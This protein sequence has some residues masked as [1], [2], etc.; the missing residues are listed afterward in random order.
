MSG[1]TPADRAH[2]RLDALYGVAPASQTDFRSIARRTKVPVNLLM[3]LDGGAGDLRAV[4]QQAS[5]I[6]EAVSAGKPLEAA[7]AEVAGDEARGMAILETAYDLADRMAPAPEAAPGR[8]NDGRVGLGEGIAGAARSLGGGLV[9]ASGGALD[10]LGVAADEAWRQSFSDD[11]SQAS[12]LRRAGQAAGD[13]ARGA[14]ESIMD[15]AS[16]D[17]K[18]RREGFQ[19]SGNLADPSSWSLGD[20]PSIWGAIGLTAEGLGSM[21][22]VVAAGLLTKNP[23]I[24]GSI[25][26]GLM[27]AGEGVETGRQFVQDAA[28]TLDENGRPVIEGLPEYK[29]LREAGESH[30]RA[31]SE[32]TRRAENDAG[33]RQGMVAGLGGAATN[34]I[35]LSADGWLGRGGRLARAGKKGAASALEE[36]AQ[37]TAEGVAGGSGIEAATG[38]DLDLMD[39]SFGDFVAGAL[40]GG[41]MGAGA[42]ALG[43]SNDEPPASLGAAP[44]PSAPLAL[45][46]PTNGGTIFGRPPSADLNPSMPLGLPAPNNGGAIIP[47]APPPG[48]LGL[49]APEPVTQR[50]NPEIAGAPLGG[51][52]PLAPAGGSSQ[53]Q[54]AAPAPVSSP[55]IGAAVPPLGA[56]P[57]PAPI[58]PPAPPAG[59]VEA[60]AQQIA[61]ATP[62]PQAEPAPRFPD[63]KPGA[64]VTLGN[65]D[66]ANENA[67]FLR[68]TP[69]GALVRIQG[70]EIE[71][72]PEQF[73]QARNQAEVNQN[74]EETSRGELGGISVAASL[75]ARPGPRIAMT[76]EEEFARMTPEEARKR[77]VALEAG[78]R[79]RGWNTRT[80]NLRTILLQRIALG[81][82][83]N[84]ESSVAEDPAS[85]PSSPLGLRDGRNDGSAGTATGGAAVQTGAQDAGS[86]DMRPEPAGTGPAPVSGD[87]GGVDV[88][89]DA[90]KL[91][92]ALNAAR[93]AGLVTHTTKKGKPKVGYVLQGV[94]K[95]EADA[96]DPYSFRKDGGIFVNAARADAFD[97]QQPAQIDTQ[98]GLSGKD[99][100]QPPQGNGTSA[101]PEPLTV[102]TAAAN[103]APAPTDAQK[104]A[105]NYRKGHA[106]WNGLDLSI[107][108]AKGQERSGTDPNGKPWSV[109]MPADYGYFRR[110]E[111]SDGDQVDFYMGPDEGSDFV[112]VVDQKDLA[113]GAFDEHKVILGTNSAAEAMAIYEAG[114][115][116]GRGRER[117]GGIREMHPQSLRAW[118]NNGDLTKPA[119]PSFDG[120]ARPMQ[121]TS[122]QKARDQEAKPASTAPE[123]AAVGVDPRE[124]SEI[125]AEFNDAQGGMVQDGDRIHHLFDAPKKSEIVRL[126]QKAEVRSVTRDG[127][128]VWH[129]DKGWMTPAE[130]RAQIEEWKAHARAQGET[131]ENADKVVLSLFDLTGSWSLPWEEAGYQVFRFDIQADPEMGDVNNFSTDFFGDW[132]GDFDGM[133]IYAILAACPCTDFASSGSRHFAAKDA[134]G[135]TVASV[136]LVHQ[137][138]ATIEHFRPAVWAIEN[139]VGRI[140]KLGGLPPWRLSFEPFHLGDTYTKT[141]LLW[142]RFNG[143]LPV[144][145]VEPV[146]GSKM[147]QKYGGK[148]LATKNARSATPEG[149]AYGFFMANNATDHP[150]MA[151]ANK[152]DRLDR[153]LI[154]QAIEAGVTA[155]AIT[156]AVS[157]FYYMELD[158]A[159]ANQAIRDLMKPSPSPKGQ[160]IEDAEVVSTTPPAR[161]EVERTVPEARDASEFAAAIGATA[162]RPMTGLDSLDFDAFDDKT[163]EDGQNSPAKR[164]GRD[165]TGRWAKAVVKALTTVAG[166][167]PV[168]DKKGKAQKPVSFGYGMASELDETNISLAGKNGVQVFVKMANGWSRGQ[169]QTI[170]FQ[171]TGNPEKPGYS[172]PF[173]GG[174]TFIPETATPAEAAAMIARAV[175]RAEGAAEQKAVKAAADQA[176]SKPA[177]GGASNSGQTP[178]A[179]PAAPEPA[180]DHPIKKHLTGQIEREKVKSRKARAAGDNS[181]AGI[182]DATLRRLRMNMWKAEEAID[183]AIAAKDFAPFAPHQ[184]DFPIA[185]EALRS[186]I[187]RIAPA[188]QPDVTETAPQRGPENVTRPGSGIAAA[189][190]P[191]DQARMAELKK[192]LAARLRTQ[193]SSGLDPEILGMA[194]EL[195]GLY[196]KAGARKFGAMLRDFMADTGLTASESQRYMRAAYGDVRDD[197]DLNGE[198]VSGFD[199]ADQVMA[200]VRAALAEE[201]AAPAP[202]ANSQEAPDRGSIGQNAQKEDQPDDR[203]GSDESDDRAG[204]DR[205]PQDPEAGAERPQG[206]RRGRGDADAGQSRSEPAAGRSGRGRDDA[207]DGD[208]RGDGRTDDARRVEAPQN[209]VIPEGGLELTGGEKTRAR[210]AVKAIEIVRALEREG[211]PATADER[212]ALAKYGGA[213]V[214]APALPNS[215]GRIRMQDIA[216]D[217]DR[218]LTPEERATV[219]KTSQYAFYTAEPVLRNMW[220]LAQRLGFKGGEVFE[221]GMGVG[222]FAGTM[223][224]GVNGRYHGIELD[225]ITAKI[226]AALYPRHH[227]KHGDFIQT[228]MPRDFYDLVIGNPP[229]SQTKITADPAYPQGFMI[230]DYFFA[231]SLDSVRPGGLLMFVTSA[232]TM[233]KRDAKAR[234]YLADRADLVGAVR[235]P[236]TAFAENG[237][238]VTTDIIVLRKRLE[239]EP[240]AN[241]AWRESTPVSV[242]DGKGGTVELNV[243][244]YFQANPEMILGE[245]GAFDTLVGAPRIGVRP[246]EGANLGRDLQTALASFPENV[247]SAADPRQMMDGPRDATSAETKT[248]SYYLKDG[249]LWQF[250]GREGKPVQRKGKSGGGMS[251]ADYDLIS[252]LVPIRNALRAVYAADLAEADATQ[253]RAELNRLY[254]EFVAKNGPINKVEESYRRPSAVELEGM[255]QRAAEDARSA[256]LGFD[257]GSFDAG[258]MIE[259]G[260]SMAAIARARREAAQQPGYR[261]GTFDP[262]AVPDKVL[263]R[264]PN[265]DAFRQDPESFRLRAIEKFDR[266]TGEATKTRVF[267]ENA[268]KKATQPKISSPEDAL[269]YLLA[270]TGRI[271]L[272]RIAEL[273]GSAPATVRAELK[274][275]IFLNPATGEF[276][277]RTRYLSGNVRRKLAEAEA[278]ISRD[279]RFAENAEELRKVIPDPIPRSGIVIPLGAHWFDHGFYAEF[280]KSKGLRLEATFKKALGR[281]N[282]EGDDRSPAAKN[283]WG[284]E[285]VP[286]AD[287]MR[288]AMNNKPMRVTRTVKNED[289]TTTSFVDEEATQAASDKAAE[290]QAAFSEWLWS[291]EARAE[292]LEERYNEVFNAEVA[293]V[294]DGAYLT[295]PGIN[296]GW[297]WRP[298]QTAV[299]ARILQSGSTYMA[300]AVGAG[301]TSAMIGA[302]MEARRLGIAQRPWYSVPNHMLV[303]FATE[304]QEQYPLANILV[305]DETNFQGDRRRQFVADAASGD[306]DAVI[307]THSAFELIPSSPAAKAAVVEEMLSDLRE[308]IEDMGDNPRDRQAGQDQALLGALRSVAGALGIKEEKE[309]GVSTAKKIAQ[310]MEQAEQRLTA[311]TQDTGKDEVFTFDEIGVDM[312][313][314]DEAH[315]FRKLSFATTNGTIKGIDPKGSAMSMDLFI[316]SRSVERRNPGRGLVL[317]SGTPITNT[318]AELYSLQRFMQPQAL[319]DKNISAFDSW[320]ATFGQVTSELEQTPDGGYKE[321]SRFSKF[322]NT[323]ELSLMVRQ[324]MDIVTS[325]DLEKYVTRPKLRG[326]GRNLVVV[327]ATPEQKAYQQD[328]ARRMRA[329]QQRKGPPKPGDDIMLNVVN[330]GRLAAIDMRL[331]DPNSTGE[332]SKLERL[333]QNVYAG[334]KAGANA[335]L[336]GVKPEGG[337]TD[338]P[339]MRGPTTQIVFS[340]LGVSPSKHNPSFSVHRHIKASLIRMGVPESDIIMA[341]DLKSHVAKQRAFND[342][343]DGKRRIL[344][345][346][347]NLF[348]GV[349]AQRRLAQIHNLDP[350]WFPAD[351]E[352]RNGRGIRQG[353][354][355]PEIAINDYSTK[356][357]YD[358]TMWQM[359]ERKAGFISGFYRGDPTMRDMEDLGEESAFA[360]AKAMTTSDPRV[361]QLTEMKTERDKLRRRAGAVD[362]QR[363]RLRAQIRGAMRAAEY[364][365]DEER[366][367]SPVAAMIPDLSG[368][369][370]KMRVGATEFDSRKEAGEAIMARADALVEAGK[371]VDDEVIGNIGGFPVEARY[372]VISQV[373]GLGIRHSPA[374]DLADAEFSDDPVGLI[375]KLEYALKKPERYVEFYQADI[376][377][378]DRA[379]AALRGQLEGVKEFADQGKLD[380]LDAEIAELEAAL[381]ADAAAEA[382][383]AKESRFTDDPELTPA[384]A[385]QINAAARAELEKVGIAGRVRAE[386]GGEGRAA[387]T[388]QRGVIRIL[389]ARSGKWRHT[390]DHEIIH[391]LRDPAIWGGD[392]GIFTRDE[393]RALVRAARADEGIAARVEAA[394]SDLDATGQTEEMVAELYADWAQA[395]REAPAGPVRTAFD[396]IRSFFR[397]VASAL[398]GEGFQDAAR[399][400]ER[401]ANGRIGG[402]GP[403]GP[404]GGVSPA[405]EQRDTTSAAFRRW[406]GDSK[407]VDA[408]GKPR[409][410][411]HATKAGDFEAFDTNISS[412][413]QT[414]GRG[415]YFATRKSDL[416]EHL[417]MGEYDEGARV[418]TANLSIQNPYVWDVSTEAK[419]VKLLADLDAAGIEGK[420]PYPFHEMNGRRD[421]GRFTAWAKS[422]GYD[423]V[424]V[425]SANGRDVTEIVAF[426]PTQIKSVNNRGTFE[427][428]NP[429]IREQRDM[430]AIKD[431][432]RAAS[433]RGKGR[434]ASAARAMFSRD[435]WKKSPEVFSN[436]LTDA[437]GKN[438]R[439][440]VLGAV[441]GHALFAELGKNLS[442]AQ[443]YL[444]N[445]QAMDTERNDWQARAAA[446]VDKWSKAGRQDGEANTRLM[447]L[448]HESTLAGIDPSKPDDWVHPSADSARRID[449]S[450]VA[451]PEQRAFARRV[452]EEIADHKATYSRLK[453]A[454]DALPAEFQTLYSEIRDEYAAMADATDSAVLENVSIANEVAVKRARRQHAKEMQRIKDE[455]LTGSAKDEAIDQADARLAATEKRARM[456]GAARIAALRAAFETNRMQ[457]PYFPL[458]R[459]G[460]YFVTV[461]DSA[462]KVISF[463]RFE[464]KE[465]QQAAIREAEEDGAAE[466]WQIEHGVLGGNADLKGMVDPRFVSE[467]EGILAETGAS[468][469]TMD[470][471]WQH[472]LETLPD[473][474]VRKSRIHRK[475]RKGF[476]QDA[477]RAFSSAMFHGAHNLAR[478][479]YGLRMDENLND[480]EEQAARQRDPERAGFVV[481]E[482]RQRHAFTMK[483]TNNPLVTAGTSLAFIWYLGMSPA[484][485]MVNITQTTVFGIPILGTR[486][487]KAGVTGAAD[488]LARASA[489]FARGKGWAERSKNLTA[490][491]RAAMQRGY[492]LGTIDKTQAHDLAAV[493]ESGVEYRPGREKAMRVIGF[494]F[495]HAERLNR[496]V[497]FLAA[498]RLARKEGLAHESAIDEAAALTWRTHFD[499]QN[500]SRPRMMQGDF[501][502][503]I[504]TFRNFTVNAL[505]RLFRDTHQAFAGDSPEAR[506]EAR[507][508]LVGIT[509]SMMAHAGIK[510]VWGF[511]L[512][513]GLLGL[514]FPGGDGDDIEDWLQDA[515]LVEGDGLGTASWNW[516]MG[517]LLHGVPGHA[518]G[519]SMTERVGMPN[520][521][522]RPPREGTEGQDLWT[523]YLQE[524]AGPVVGIGGNFVSGLSMISDAWGDGNSENMLRGAER[525]TPNFVSNGV[526]KPA[527]FMAYGANTY[528]GDPLMEVGPLDALRTVA[529]FTPAQLAERYR[530]NGRLRAAEQRVMSERASIHRAIGK[531]VE[532]GE[533]IPERVMRQMREFNATY[534]E[535][536]IT[537]AT[538]RQ[539]IRSRATMKERN[540]W[541]L[542]LNPKLNDRLRGELP[543]AIY[544]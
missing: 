401:I 535:Y 142:G 375:R 475:G 256:S 50:D 416:N 107:E 373:V 109:T 157:D 193:A 320:A 65:E 313:F 326:G 513:M 434:A 94:T 358:A 29:N 290:V 329:M 537:A 322:V 406:F 346:S 250:D 440:N 237:T 383:A 503:I 150:V 195:T 213:G 306:Y 512:L 165:E 460:N 324:V 156:E 185:A 402:R 95:A 301:K 481:R 187:S 31:V 479:R 179:A 15:G 404:G 269:L 47:P 364:A 70:Q 287:M 409:E 191:E 160:R 175:E 59:P 114:F 215:A 298:H 494:L 5:K 152:F 233:N 260:A 277:T 273:S 134:D 78:A 170:Y 61:A 418:I 486:F 265:I 133:D 377:K 312:L 241:P 223:P 63:Q 414:F 163:R 369:K 206:T 283:E 36:G 446:M 419:R 432:L 100:P 435:G 498:Y 470:A 431:A 128:R 523:H 58:T 145:P 437:M 388:Y 536:P 136:K 524:V 64:T 205:G 124:L 252:Q 539:S 500:T 249:E 485:A 297:K 311:M 300:H 467:V 533:P 22:P 1:N 218:L 397:A 122:A 85:G 96:M 363:S 35:L 139:P 180:A 172:R 101:N 417:G 232:G 342:M 91:G 125:V 197:M 292:M 466:G 104:E 483:P 354:M 449:R 10:A 164:K 62:A 38:A 247:M 465:A 381:L 452:A 436:W 499:Y 229:F 278:A 337:Y 149:F 491:E 167:E 415:S 227:I 282:V 474:S 541:G 480:A 385:R 53:G 542:S 190:S 357:T 151:L 51:P 291:D 345:G 204:A 207:R 137:T 23:A 210:N 343:N 379:A 25:V 341:G 372:S 471:I 30:D 378:H 182:A 224:A 198:D 442:A 228:A 147:H 284:T 515:L 33:F 325:T 501:A 258:P 304:F 421:P 335:P 82:P 79:Q 526:I 75:G 27:G 279:I 422:Q 217:L 202:S 368:E 430:T 98:A 451:S 525:I 257:I 103:V 113:T 140:E 117:I 390:L 448:M 445:K 382:E 520:L 457:G 490:D 461:R 330:D 66:G 72:T 271:D 13:A 386:V 158:D 392:A 302:G 216:A 338:K 86:V 361:L 108:T 4:E 489:D 389:R 262:E 441:P 530:I 9:R 319:D 2:A 447:D 37:E 365:R 443:T 238:Q 28:K 251:K 153:D 459:F 138:L 359:M 20:D 362:T 323:P 234:N 299:V 203:N 144:A 220:A 102:A 84:V 410:V 166:M 11:P 248:G 173:I 506:R 495:H 18:A 353:N 543:Q 453:A 527:R 246:R 73:D 209:H 8:G 395:R 146:E 356:G 40:S 186:E 135:R 275:K 511:G 201:K 46:A 268:V 332:G 184:A 97:V 88:A 288:R 126:G 408:D 355:N 455:G 370:F 39:D 538:I 120:P 317:A 194:V 331:V 316:K 340:T 54:T 129:R 26:G 360:Q 235:L 309:K 429:N 168:K 396:R 487:R 32:L 280:A 509:L 43:R 42:G 7:V 407:V 219:E 473:R 105:G 528:R 245:Q 263:E 507:G 393:W 80:S 399:I 106:R 17:F 267:T 143:D 155:D 469:E 532:A 130:A 45:P 433:G 127:A 380:K 181:K 318:M 276:E 159:A 76:V 44:A 196:I 110:T 24:A 48:A 74:R 308:L 497:T 310:M 55:G 12:G 464:K 476:N 296:T 400:M 208:G 420:G 519:V 504:L 274:G 272:D 439:F 376:A 239:G 367:I 261:E 243:N 468:P 336:H 266:A 83:A 264:F 352:Q 529:G 240:E 211:R 398:R 391:A 366:K 56:A 183:A 293:P 161:S 477:V 321:V 111:G 226:A 450:D 438:E 285:D 214:L 484:A 327:E 131:R 384:L 516:M 305:A 57:A 68:E 200:E 222:G 303:Q 334:W 314:V 425:M 374:M 148:S 281:W 89:D 505:Y 315:L 92:A 90:G 412:P 328:L 21:A 178:E 458:A 171:I 162:N 502:K 255:R 169:T 132:F 259:A 522:F 456:N 518:M 478:L 176:V 141:T 270:D 333:I 405:R 19:P 212:A 16:E 521:W 463:S 71:L 242:P 286:F 231:K 454:H 347:K 121:P 349:N 188:V 295:T 508:Q 177:E 350:L 339:K 289:G 77:L 49:P 344:I 348:T 225:H 6:A 99:A 230:H 118:L 488:A 41:V 413:D 60:I 87:L 351:D 462:G 69:N 294:Y 236:N 199:T 510:G 253:A 112:L 493:A 411:Y 93:A 189:L 221:P 427:P 52:A 531:A 444:K 34:R 192:K 387:G 423:G 428:D 514:A 424:F 496:E 482:M 540:E 517:M 123:H 426:D 394:Y 119:S 14:G 116:D 403:D 244:R 492:E 3:A 534:P 544:S 371:S 254:D 67:V 81:E 472:W 154:E 307:I 174:N 115:S